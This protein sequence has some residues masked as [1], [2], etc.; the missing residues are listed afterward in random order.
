VIFGTSF[1]YWKTR[2][3]KIMP[4]NPAKIVGK[5][6]RRKNIFAIFLKNVNLLNNPNK[7]KD[8]KINF[9]YPIFSYKT[10]F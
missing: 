4:K 10:G 5:Y 2:W 8:C 6:E 3:S 1:Y 7:N 9:F